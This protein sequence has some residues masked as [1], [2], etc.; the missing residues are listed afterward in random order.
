[1]DIIPEIKNRFT[2]SSLLAEAVDPKALQ[3]V[4]EAGRLAP[5]AKNRQP[6]RFILIRNP[7]TKSRLREACFGD[8]KVE[9]APA[10]IAICTTNTEY[11][12]PNSHLSWPI[13]LTF[14]AS[15]MVIQAQHV[16]LSTIIYSSFHEDE[17]RQILTVPHSMRVLL[18]L[19]IGKSSENKLEPHDRLKKERV[20]SEDHW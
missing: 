9:N 14:A 13:D 18:L 7:Q 4:L 2:P 6:W 17:V 20:I 12:M 16:G 3:S 5:S 10:I 15:F 19:L 8:E 11:R 1:M